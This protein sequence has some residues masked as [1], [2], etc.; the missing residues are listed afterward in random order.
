[1]V[2]VIIQRE[3]KGSILGAAVRRG[4]KKWLPMARLALNIKGRT[5]PTVSIQDNKF[6]IEAI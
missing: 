2:E 4:I 5:V 6:V 1:V 3:G